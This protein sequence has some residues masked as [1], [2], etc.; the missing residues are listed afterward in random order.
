MVLD[1]DEHPHSGCST[2]R[3]ADEAVFS[4][5]RVVF[6]SPPSYCHVYTVDIGT[7]DPAMM[8]SF[9]VSGRSIGSRQTRGACCGFA[10]AHAHWPKIDTLA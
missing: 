5:Y 8:P 6:I 3:A 7:T 1:L 9:R 4:M 10:H 2:P